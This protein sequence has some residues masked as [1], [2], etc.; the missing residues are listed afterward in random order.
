MAITL[1]LSDRD[2]TNLAFA[3]RDAAQE[4]YTD[5]RLVTAATYYALAARVWT[6][7]GSPTN[8]AHSTKLA[9]A[10]DQEAVEAAVQA[11]VDELEG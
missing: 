11:A 5:A 2:A 3:L 8:A 7:A 4:A 6:A 1:T 10:I 9:Q